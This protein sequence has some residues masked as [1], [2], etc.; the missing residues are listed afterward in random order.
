MVISMILNKIAYAA[1][2]L[3][4]Q[5]RLDQAAI[6][7]LGESQV[8]TYI[9]DELHLLN[10]ILPTELNNTQYVTTT[11]TLS[12]P[13]NGALFTPAQNAAAMMFNETTG[14]WQANGTETSIN[15][16]LNQL[17]FI[18]APHF[19]GDMTIDTEI[20]YPNLSVL[21]GKLH[22][23]G[24]PIEDK[25]I[26]HDDQSSIVYIANQQSEIK[27]T[28][29]LSVVDVDNDELT[30]AT[31]TM[32]GPSTPIDP[33]N[34]FLICPSGLFLIYCTYNP[35]TGTLSLT[36]KA[37]AE[38]YEE[39]FRNIYYRQNSFLLA[40][41]IIRMAISDGK[42][43]SEFLYKSLLTHNAPTVTLSHSVFNYAPHQAPI[44]IFP[45]IT[46]TL[47]NFIEL[48]SASVYIV[49][50]SPS[51]DS[52]SAIDYLNI[53][54]H[55]NNK[56]CTLT[57]TGINS[58]ANYIQ[59]INNVTYE[60]IDDNI[61]LAPRNIAIQINDSVSISTPAS[62][63]VMVTSAPN[64]SSSHT[65]QYKNETSSSS[66]SSFFAPTRTHANASTS[67]NTTAI[68]AVTASA[69]AIALLASAAGLF[70]YRKRTATYCNKSL[71]FGC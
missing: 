71:V 25:P 33:V 56:T 43:D 58:I 24:I 10:L 12:N 8:I 31:I 41:R 45:N 26:L 57:L 28:P 40:S 61:Q 7:I 65:S 62:L 59:V 51:Q 15:D 30:N 35:E 14:I 23:M 4:S 66:S 70:A 20:I 16:L 34:E 2:L 39:A 22:L 3:H 46:I 1:L 11:L 53:Q 60:F 47:E 63:S 48:E 68:V 18:P 32:M 69:G 55:F 38:Q 50:C 44:Y 9:E 42:M 67:S 19:F 64:S 21:T 49:N 29:T 54:H 36:G 37:S 6:S 17:Y 5:K 27:I 13:L 52:L